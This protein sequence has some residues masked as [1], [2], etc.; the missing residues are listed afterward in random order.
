MLSQHHVQSMISLLMWICHGLH[1]VECQQPNNWTLFF[2]YIVIVQRAYAHLASTLWVVFYKQ[3]SGLLPTVYDNGCSV[4]SLGGCK[5]PN[6]STRYPVAY[7]KGSNKNNPLNLTV[8][9]I[10]ILHFSTMKY[11]WVI[12]HLFGF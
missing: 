4:W 6:H 2:L 9:E 5:P 3:W 8:V 1:E 11:I 10:Y 7:T 12:K